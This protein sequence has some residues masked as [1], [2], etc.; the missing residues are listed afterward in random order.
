MNI[1]KNKVVSLIYELMVDGSLA[2]KTVKE[3]PLEFIFGCGM[4]L[5]K[6]EEYIAGLEPGSK[7]QFTLSPEE[8]YGVSNPENIIE[9]PIAAFEVDGKLRDD[10]LKVGTIVPLSN[11]QGA[12]FQ[13][14]VLEVGELFVKMDLN[15]PMADKTLNFTGEILAVR[16]ATEEELR[17]G[18]HGEFAAAHK[19]QGCHGDCSEGSCDK[20]GCEGDCCSKN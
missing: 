5:P 10:L 18:L 3:R 6:F 16:E 9:L 7:F 13:A 20:D 11:G 19:C 14:K 15:H 4:L 2:D 17:D 8:G 1:E 12:V